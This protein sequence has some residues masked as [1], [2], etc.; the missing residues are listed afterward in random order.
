MMK[1][2]IFWAILFILPAFCPQI[3]EKMRL[4]PLFSKF[5]RVLA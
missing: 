4:W 2:L 5:L 1:K 3:F